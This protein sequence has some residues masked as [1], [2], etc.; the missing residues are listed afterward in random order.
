MASQSADASVP[1]RI[2]PYRVVGRLGA[3]GMGVTYAAEDE[4]LGRLVALEVLRAGT[5]DP[6]ARQRLVREARTAAAVSHPRICQVFELGDWN[7]EPF[8]AMELLEGEPLSARLG[9]GAL[10]PPEALAIAR[11]VVEALEVLHGRGIAHRDLKPSNIFVTPVGVKV[12]DFGLARP[13]D[14]G[15]GETAEALT[16][17]GTFVGT[18]QYASPEQLTGGRRSSC[19]R[20]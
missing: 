13:I 11:S 10:P 19:D 8:I 7:G 3:G 17:A 4:R 2:G 16:A 15:Q 5:G 20:A 9:G 14:E 18:P 12:L 1:D 6:V